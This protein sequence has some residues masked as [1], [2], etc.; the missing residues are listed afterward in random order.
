G[1]GVDLVSDLTDKAVVIEI[2][3]ELGYTKGPHGMDIDK[4]KKF[5]VVQAATHLLT[6]LNDQER[7]SQVN[8]MWLHIAKKMSQGVVY[9]LAGYIADTIVEEVHTRRKD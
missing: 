5:P 3:K 8:T 7:W 4:L 1:T 2:R 6:K 9:N